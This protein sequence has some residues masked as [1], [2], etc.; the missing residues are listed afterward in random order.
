MRRRCRPLLEQAQSSAGWLWTP[1]SIGTVAR[2]FAGT[3]VEA[4]NGSVRSL[5][6]GRYVLKTFGLVYAAGLYDY[7]PDTVAVKLTRKCVN[8]LKPGGSFLFGNFSQETDVDGYMET[9]MNWPLLLRTQEKCG[10]SLVRV[11]AIRMSMFLFGSGPIAIS[12]I[13]KSKTHVATLFLKSACPTW[14][15][16]ISSAAYG[17]FLPNP[18]PGS[19]PHSNYGVRARRRRKSNVLSPARK[20]GFCRRSHFDP[21]GREEW[22]RRRIG[23]QG[24]RQYHPASSMTPNR[25]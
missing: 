11:L 16:H 15:R 6:G 23:L 14:E 22:R 24:P 21:A 3:S 2:D 25:I 17:V 8:M 5:L 19:K 18:G 7:L 10:R 1:V 4:V 13:A 12:S 9:F 20:Q